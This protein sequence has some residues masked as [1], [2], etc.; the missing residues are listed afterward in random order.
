MPR[1]VQNKKTT[2]PANNNSHTAPQYPD[3]PS[4]RKAPKTIT[5]AVMPPL[6]LFRAPLDGDARAGGVVDLECAGAVGGA[7]PGDLAAIRLADP[8]RPLLL[9]WRTQANEVARA[10]TR[11]EAQRRLREV[12]G[13]EARPEQEAG[14]D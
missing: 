4:R 11:L 1:Y 9:R 12:L 5:H 3:S 8:E 10:I 2:P 6:L 13:D 7:G 14:A